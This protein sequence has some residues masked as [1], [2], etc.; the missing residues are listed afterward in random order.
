M[1]WLSGQ[2]RNRVQVRRIV[3][4]VNDAGGYDVSYL[5]LGTVWAEVLPIT[6]ERQ[7]IAAFANYVRG[8]NVSNW[9]THTVKIRH[10]FVG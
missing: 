3:Q 7:G 4:T 9:N 5:V 8:V 2:L 10:F 6:S 1:S